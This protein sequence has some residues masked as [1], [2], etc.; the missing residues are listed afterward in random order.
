MGINQRGLDVY[1]GKGKYGNDTAPGNCQPGGAAGFY[2]SSAGL[3]RY[4]TS[5]ASYLA[6]PSSCK[7]FWIPFVAGTTG[8]VNVGLYTITRIIFPNC[9]IIVGK[10]WKSEIPSAYAENG[11]E[12]S[13]SDYT[14]LQCLDMTTGELNFESL[15]FARFYFYFLKC[16]FAVYQHLK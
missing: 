11:K 1:I 3:E 7:C 8:M 5:G 9:S 12:V 15:K 14:V 16:F 6:V 2:M 4:V 13:R 10:H